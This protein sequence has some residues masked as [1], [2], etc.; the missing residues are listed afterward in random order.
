MT[1]LRTT[2]ARSWLQS[3]L[4][5]DLGPLFSSSV[6]RGTGLWGKLRFTLG[7]CLG[8]L[9]PTG[10]APGLLPLFTQSSFALIDVILLGATQ[11][12][13]ENIKYVF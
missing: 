2:K 13:L 11:D 9:G 4:P 12:I 5:C 6:S 7:V 10:T 1:G 8:R 3:Y